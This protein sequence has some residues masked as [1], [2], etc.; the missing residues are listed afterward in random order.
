MKKRYVVFGCYTTRMKIEL[1]R[2]DGSYNTCAIPEPEKVIRE[3]E[4]FDIYKIDVPD[5]AVSFMFF[6]DENDQMKFISGGYIGKIYDVTKL[7]EIAQCDKNAN[8]IL[9]FLKERGGDGAIKF[10]LN[11]ADGNAW[12]SVYKNGMTVIEL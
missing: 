9:N 1:F 3:I 6:E 10:R 4:E 5:T 7:E 8:N 11:F 12:W 2:A